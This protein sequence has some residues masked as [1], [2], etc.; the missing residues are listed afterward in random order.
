MSVQELLEKMKNRYKLSEANIVKYS[1]VIGLKSVKELLNSWDIKEASS[2][3]IKNK[4]H[5]CNLVFVAMGKK[6]TEEK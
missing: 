2:D 5:Y 6:V 1:N 4:L 3:P